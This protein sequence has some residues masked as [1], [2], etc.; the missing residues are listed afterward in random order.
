MSFRLIEGWRTELHRLWVI[1][2][3]LAVGFFTGVGGAVCLL[4]D[5]FNPWFLVALSVFC[6][7]VVIPLARL[8]KQ[9]E[10]AE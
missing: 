9:M 8:A 3:S 1:R 6:N 5:F 2:V 7:V 4:G 10:P